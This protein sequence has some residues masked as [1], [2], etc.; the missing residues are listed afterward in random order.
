M[1]WGMFCW[2]G[3]GALVFLEGK[4]IALRYLDVLID[5]VHFAM[6]NFY[7]DGDE[8]F[9]DGNAIHRAKIGSLNIRLTSNTFPDHS[10]A[11]ILTP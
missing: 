8:Y 7:P 5:Q 11:W 3:S 1:I 10:I 6:L 4:Q 9:I 2:Y